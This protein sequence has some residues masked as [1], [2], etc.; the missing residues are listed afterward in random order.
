MLT[1]STARAFRCPPENKPPPVLIHKLTDLV[2]DLVTE[3]TAAS[4]KYFPFP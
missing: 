4:T 2:T 1:K 3:L